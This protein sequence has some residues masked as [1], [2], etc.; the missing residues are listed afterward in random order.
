MVLALVLSCLLLRTGTRRS[1]GTRSRRDLDHTTAGQPPTLPYSA[2][3]W[4]RAPSTTPS[5]RSTAG[6]SRISSG[7]HHLPS[8][9]KDAAAATA[10]YQ[11]LVGLHVAGLFPVLPPTAAAWL[12]TAYAAALPTIPED[13]KQD[14]SRSARPQPRRCSPHAPT[15]D[16]STRSRSSKAPIPESGGRRRPTSGATPAPGSE[17]CARSSSRASEMLR[18]DG[19]NALTSAAYAED[20]NEV[21]KLG[22]LTSTTPH[23]RPDG[24]RDLL[25]GQRHRDLEP[26]LPRAGGERAGWTSSRAPACSR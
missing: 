22:S 14:G 20:F 6:I 1:S 10:A 9:S 19:P 8:D 2:W 4:C 18:T 15:T 12:D 5:T 23:R 21:K 7:L 11:V 3:R 16:A 24:S 13:D 26:R 17:T 25:A